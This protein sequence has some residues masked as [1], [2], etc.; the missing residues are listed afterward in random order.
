MKRTVKIIALLEL[1]LA[2]SAACNVQTTGQAPQV[3]AGN[4]MAAMTRLRSIATAE[5]QYQL[6]S[7]GKFATLEELIDNRLI[8]DPS[9]GKLAGYNFKVRVRPGGFEATA[10]PVRHGISGKRSFYIDET[11]IM[12]GAEKRGDQAGPGDPEA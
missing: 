11:R 3:V 1:M 4:E 9:E 6:D 8:G 12:R 7:G 10:V 2:I 5:I